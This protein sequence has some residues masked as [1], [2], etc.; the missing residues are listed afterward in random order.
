MLG[1]VIQ[2]HPVKS[3]LLRNLKN[4]EAAKV[5][6]EYSSGGGGGGVGIKGE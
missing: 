5:L 2:L 1:V 4:N 3:F 6:K